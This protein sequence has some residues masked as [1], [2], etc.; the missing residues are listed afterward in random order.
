MH[1]S[2]DMIKIKLKFWVSSEKVDKF[3]NNRKVFFVL[4]VGRSGTKFFA[5]LLNEDDK[6]I[7]F[8]EAVSEDGK[9]SQLCIKNPGVGDK[10]IKNF[11]KKLI[12]ERL[13]NK[14][15][16]V[17]GEVNGRLRYMYDGLSKEFTSAK[18]VHLVRD[19]RDVVSSLMNRSH[20]KDKGHSSFKFYPRK[21]E[22]YYS[23]WRDLGRFEKVCW[24]WMHGNKYLRSKIGG[25]SVKFEKL[26]SDYDYFRVNLLEKID[27]GIPESNWRKAINIPINVSKKYSF[28]KWTEWSDE[29]MKKFNRICG[30]EMKKLGYY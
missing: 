17:Y 9:L 14:E 21:D 27:V 29:L 24:F 20:Y 3:F 22:E 15:F 12:Y 16:E 1:L 28:P 25:E 26:I 8:H 2:R 4:G 7:V 6:A 11:R 13:K 23:E 5:N 18:F 19:G 30:H 10:Y